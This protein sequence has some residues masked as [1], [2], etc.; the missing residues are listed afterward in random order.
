MGYRPSYLLFRTMRYAVRRPVALA[1]AEGYARAGLRRE[2][3]YEDAGVRAYLRREQ[4]FGK[5][6]RRAREALGRA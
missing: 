4:S 2:P 6:P 5:L 3:R 1:M